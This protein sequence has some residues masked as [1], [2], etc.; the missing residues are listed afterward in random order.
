MLIYI[1]VLLPKETD[2]TKESRIGENHCAGLLSGQFQQQ[3][4]M[5]RTPGRSCWGQMFATC[6]KQTTSTTKHTRQT[7][8]MMNYIHICLYLY[9]YICMYT[10]IHI[11]IYILRLP[12]VVLR[13]SLPCGRFAKLL[14]RVREARVW[15]DRCHLS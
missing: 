3:L 6:L 14:W 10:H 8:I 13:C 9:I 11:Y 5:C 4:C 1:E 15:R 12:P 7:T 2:K